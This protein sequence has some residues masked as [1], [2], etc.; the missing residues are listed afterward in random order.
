MSEEEEAVTEGAETPEA[1]EAEDDAEVRARDAGWRPKEEFK[2]DPDE[3]VPADE[4]LNYTPG[5]LRK[6]NKALER[7]ISAMTRTLDAVSKRQEEMRTQAYQDALKDIREKQRAAA[8]DGD[9]ETY[10]KLEEQREKLKEPEPDK[11]ANGKDNQDLDPALTDWAE[12]NQWIVADDV[13]LAEAHALA[14]RFERQYPASTLAQR[15]EM[16]TKE[17]SRRYGRP[18]TDEPERETRQ[19]RPSMAESNARGSGRGG[20]KTVTFADLTPEEKDAVYEMERRK[21]IGGHEDAL[22]K[23]RDEYAAYLRKYYGEEDSR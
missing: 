10:E 4:W 13:N 12:R 5:K 19:K 8:Q 23:S 7:K 14:R 2:G 1:A 18:G 20:K 6:Q 15:L 21:Q 9:M 11:S 22:F 3:W 17:M 16:I